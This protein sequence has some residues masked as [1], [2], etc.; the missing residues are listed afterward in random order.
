MQELPGLCLWGCKQVRLPR[1]GP[2]AARQGFVIDQAARLCNV[3][4]C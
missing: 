2:L 3:C 4:R 1:G